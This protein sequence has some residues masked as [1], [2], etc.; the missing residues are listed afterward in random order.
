MAAERREV[1]AT[2][3]GRAE[4]K[5]LKAPDGGAGL[6]GAARFR[7]RLSAGAEA[8]LDGDKATAREAANAF[9]QLDGPSVLQPMRNWVTFHAGLANLIAGD[10]RAAKERFGNLAERASTSQ[11]AGLATFFARSAELGAARRSRSRHP[12][13]Q[14]LNRKNYESMGLLMYGMKNWALGKTEEALALLTEFGKATPE[15]DDEWIADY[16]PLATGL[17]SDREHWQVASKAFAE[18]K[19]A[20]DKLAAAL[21]TVSSARRQLRRSNS[22]TK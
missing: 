7:P 10:H 1:S 15:G 16:Q 12:P 19:A 3:S 21:E 2:G 20:P 14:T 9:R 17:V 4:E 18:A 6:R 22:P 13:A 8:L 5:P 11:D